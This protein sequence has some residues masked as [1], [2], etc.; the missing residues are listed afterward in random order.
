MVNTVGTIVAALLGLGIVY[1]SAQSITK[2]LKKTILV[3]QDIAQGEGDLTQR[4]DEIRRD[5]LGELGKC[6]HTFIGKLEGL[7]AQ[8]AESTQGVASASQEF[9]AA[10]RQ[11]GS[12]AE[13]SSAQP[14]RVLQ[15]PQ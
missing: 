6:F 3:L 8:I 12:N 1:Y 14:R 5:E 11:H 13:E 4:V 9:V 10:S 7:I 15:G 2:P